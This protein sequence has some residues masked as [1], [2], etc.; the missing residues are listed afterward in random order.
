[1]QS[2]DGKSDR[3]FLTRNKAGVGARAT[4]PGQAERRNSTS[5]DKVSPKDRCREGFCRVRGRPAP[6]EILQAIFR[7]KETS[8]TR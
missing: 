5:R 6:P 7:R 4:W 8:D 3:E 1:M 2:K